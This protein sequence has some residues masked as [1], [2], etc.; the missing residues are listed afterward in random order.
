MITAILL[1]LAAVVAVFIVIVA[2]RPSD[3]RISRSATIAAPPEVI[4]E[5]VNDLHRFQDWSPWMKRDPNARSIYEGPR[6]GTGAVFKWAGNREVGEGIMTI[7]ESRPH[8]L[9]RFRLEFLKPFKV[10]NAAEFT[11]A[12]EGGQTRVTWSMYGKSR[13]MCKAI[14]LFV[15]MDDMCGRDFE[16]G[17]AAMREIAEATAAATPSSNGQ[18]LPVPRRDF[19]T[20]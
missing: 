19:A 18:H 15:N 9:V 4:F 1:S 2:S 10:T 13:F 7:T 6:A 11:F 17:L 12:R 14:G 8:E 5:Q 16:K 20:A 3:F